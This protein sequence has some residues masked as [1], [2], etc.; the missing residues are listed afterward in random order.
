MVAG[1]QSKRVGGRYKISS[2]ITTLREDPGSKEA[3]TILIYITRGMWCHY[4]SP[5]EES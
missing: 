3:L 5:S 2:E 4:F 1:R